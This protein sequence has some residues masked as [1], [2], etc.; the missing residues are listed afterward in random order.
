MK[1][2]LRE[3]LS[4]PG[5]RRQLA[6]IAGGLVA[7]VGAFEVGQIRAGHNALQ[8]EIAQR[9]LTRQVAA[10]ET[11]NRLTMAQL[12]RLQTDAKIDRETYS[13]VEAQ[14]AELQGKIIEQQEEVAFYRG[15]IGG[16]GQ[17]GLK[18]QDFALTAGVPPAINLR[19]MLAQTERAEREVQGQM[20]IRVEGL[21]GGRVVSIDVANLAAGRTAGRLAFNVRYFQDVAIELRLPADFTP[22][23]VVIRVLPATRV[24]KD[25]VESFPWAIRNS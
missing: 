19:F 25:S 23:R 8:A 1:F 22:Q 5:Q 6:A 9:R 18:V 21:R 16:P 12:A 24:V 10:L 11:E 13:Q 17:G 7:L 3:F 14:L 2:D 20:Q 15:V 4:V